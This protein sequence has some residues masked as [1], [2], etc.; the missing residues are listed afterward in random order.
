MADNLPCAT[1]VYRQVVIIGTATQQLKAITLLLGQLNSNPSY[2]T[3]CDV[4]PPMPQPPGSRR[5]PS[6]DS[7]MLQQQLAGSMSAMGILFVSWVGVASAPICFQITSAAHR[8]CHLSPLSNHKCCSSPLSPSPRSPPP[9]HTSPVHIGGYNPTA[10]LL[11]SLMP[12]LTAPQQLPPVLQA[13]AALPALPPAPSAV[14]SAAIKPLNNAGQFCMDVTP[15]QAAV[16]ASVEGQQLLHR[17]QLVRS[18]G[19][20]VC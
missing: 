5:A 6:N 11:Q 8:R 4:P 2:A 12:Q 20:I 15:D 13:L 7:S 17:V 1:T 10:G 19:V 18:A 14:P 9:P 16:L 3:Y